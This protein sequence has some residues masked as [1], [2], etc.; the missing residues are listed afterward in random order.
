MSSKALPDPVTVAKL[1]AS[2]IGKQVNQ[3]SA[4]AMNK[5]PQGGVVGVFKNDAQEIVAIVVADVSLAAAT[6]AALAMIPAT[7]AQ[8]AIRSGALPPNMAENFREVINVMSSLLTGGGNRAVRLTEC[9]IG[10]VPEPASNTF[11]TP[12]GRLDLELEIQGYGKG[13]LSFFAA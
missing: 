7:A 2:L 6:G 12:G 10:T 8:D 3:K 9:S 11:S 5:L 1:V 4:A 13:A